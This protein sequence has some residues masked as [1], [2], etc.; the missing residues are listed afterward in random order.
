MSSLFIFYNITIS[1]PFP[2]DGFS[3]NFFNAWQWKRSIIDFSPSLR[4]VRFPDL[5]IFVELFAQIYKAQYGA[6]MLVYLYGTPTW[7]PENSANI[8]NLLW[9]SRLVII[10][11]EQTGIYL[12]TFLDA[13]TSIKVQNHDISTYILTNL[14]AALQMRINTF[15]AL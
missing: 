13:L 12:S 9:L 15:V 4:S 10:W 11:T 1:W 3:I 2:L 14:I 5:Q 6:A 7:R 8:W